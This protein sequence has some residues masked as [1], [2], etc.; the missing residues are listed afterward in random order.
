VL[1]PVGD[2]YARLGQHQEACNCFRSVGDEPIPNRA[3]PSKPSLDIKSP[4]RA[5]L[6]LESILKL[7]EQ[8]TPA[9]ALQRSTPVVATSESA[10]NRGEALS[11]FSPGSGINIDYRDVCERIK[12]LRS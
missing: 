7:A 6:P 8:Y 12:A 9:G 3:S 2:L 4:P 5:G 11:H 10:Q 1:N